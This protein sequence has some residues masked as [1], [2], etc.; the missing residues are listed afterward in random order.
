MPQPDELGPTNPP[1]FG[2]TVISTRYDPSV[3]T[4]R[5]YNWEL[6][7]QVQHEL[8]PRTS[9][10]VGYFRRWY[11]N[12]RVTDNLSI[13][14]ADYSPYSVVAPSDPRLP[15]GGGYTVS[16]LYDPDFLAAQNNVIALASNYGKASEVYNGVDLT[17]NLRLPHNVVL[18]G[19]PSIGR[20][21]T[22]YCFTVDSPQGTGIPPSQGATTTGGLLYCDVK[23]P[24]QANV[25]LLGV[26]PLPWWGVQFS[27]TFQ[28]V[29]GP[30]ITASRTYTS[31]QIAP[32]LGRNLA[33]GANGTAAVQLIKPGTMFDERLYQVDLRVSKQFRL[34][35]D[36]RIQLNL[37][38]YNAA[39]ASPVLSLNTA[40]GPSWMTPTS[41]LQGRLIKIGTQWD[42]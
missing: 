25:K 3:L 2:S 15:G 40:Y 16:G 29:P 13:T 19:G 8:L 17:A 37:D 5:M 14:P 18:S 12:L 26:Y 27:G 35:G 10:N 38:V 33:T 41:I 36:H 39:N 1:N 28:S 11:G 21:E 4:H 30:M 24:F 42:F 7:A 23:P 31:A 20:T 22:N 32:S 34:G 6:S 9:V